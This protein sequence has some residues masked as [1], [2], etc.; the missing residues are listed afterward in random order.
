MKK[1][2]IEDV[3]DQQRIELA[4]VRRELGTLRAFRDSLGLAK[5]AST[6]IARLEDRAR[7]LEEA[8]AR[9]DGGAPV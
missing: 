4:R 2:G 8:L 7:A 3:S 1:Y 5:Q 9:G 6:E